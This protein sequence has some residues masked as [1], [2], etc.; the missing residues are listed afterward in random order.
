MILEDIKA[1]LVQANVGT[2]AAASGGAPQDWQVFFNYMQDQPDRAICIYETPGPAPEE[3]WAIEYPSF[4]IK[5]RG[6]PDDAEAARAKL[7]EIFQ[8][9]QGSGRGFGIGTP[10]YVYIYAAHSGALPMG[11]DE[12]R[13]PSFAQNYRTMKATD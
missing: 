5:V 1:A 8:T 13:R 3:K 11:Q 7:T 9:L 6:G 12:N 10:Y 4:Q 2:D